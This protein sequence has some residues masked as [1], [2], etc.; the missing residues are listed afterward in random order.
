MPLVWLLGLVGLVLL[1]ALLLVPPRSIARRPPAGSARHHFHRK[2][3]KH[4]KHKRCKKRRHKPRK[5]HRTP[6]CCKT[7]GA[8]SGTTPGLAPL[9]EPELESAPP[10]AQVPPAQIAQLPTAS[11]STLVVAGVH[12]YNAGEF[13]STPPSPE[14]PEG[15]LVKVVGSSING[16]STEVQ[17]EPGSFY[18]AVP[19]GEINVDLNEPGAS[20]PENAAARRLMSTAGAQSTE[21]HDKTVSC[22]GGAVLKLNTSF[23]RELDPRLELR[24]HKRLGIPTGI[25]NAR[26]TLDAGVTAEVSAS[27]S[28]AATCK[29]NPITL[30][31]PKWEIPVDVG[32]IVVPVKIEAPIQLNASAE[33]SGKASVS[34]NAEM[35]GSVGAA[36]ED[37]GIHGVHEFSTG[38]S[39]HH[40][41]QAK[42]KLRVGIGPQISVKAGWSVPVLGTLGAEL[43]SGITAGPELNFNIAS[44]PPGSLCAFL[45]VNAAVGLDLPHEDPIKAG[46]NTFY[47]GDIACAHFG[48]EEGENETETGEV[49]HGERGGKDGEPGFEEEREAEELKTVEREQEEQEERRREIE[50]EEVEARETRLRNEIELLE[51]VAPGAGLLKWTGTVRTSLQETEIWPSTSPGQARLELEGLWEVD[52]FSAERIPANETPEEEDDYGFIGSDY[53]EW[54]DVES[55]EYSSPECSKQGYVDESVAHVHQDS[56]E[57]GEVHYFYRNGTPN[58]QDAPR[59]GE[60]PADFSAG[61]SWGC[62]DGAAWE[63]QVSGSTGTV[64]APTGCQGGQAGQVVLTQGGHAFASETRQDQPMEADAQGATKTFNC[65]IVVDLTVQCREPGEPESTWQPPNDNFECPDAKP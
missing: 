15:F 44:K 13:L 49:E 25:D 40:S 21:E 33:V 3:K 9:P 64:L 23:E 10:L 32:P 46:P 31:T 59:Y 26:V 58:F 38:S 53:A 41:V 48:E 57:A 14:A 1:L 8:D 35:H 30:A 6:P 56:I 55:E 63:E 20:I 34:A 37:G 28:G 62:T 51:V 60:A 43:D 24:W 54:S 22:S 50:E 45:D 12:S 16:G 2:C 52:G 61:K 42:A 19:N 36:Y 18:E 5:I 11:D 65:S 17:T 29:L 4:G 7:T 27:V 47:D 39:L